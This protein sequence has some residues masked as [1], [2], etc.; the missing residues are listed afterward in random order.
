[1]VCK[2][3][4]IK[5]IKKIGVM[6]SLKLLKDRIVSPFVEIYCLNRW[7]KFSKKRNYLGINK[8]E[9]KIPIIVSMTTFPDRIENVH[10]VIKSLL[11][12][13]F[14]PDKIILWLAEEQ[15]PNKINDLPNNLLKLQQYGL[16]ISWCSDIRSYKK[17]IPTIKNYPNSFIIT[18]DDDIY[19]HPKMIERLFREYKRDPQ[20]I[21]CH[22]VTKFYLE[23][24]EFKAISG[25]YDVYNH[26]SFLNKLTGGSGTLYPPNSLYKDICRQ[27]LF[28]KLAPTNDD[29]WFWVMAILN[30]KRC[31]VVSNSCTA[32][33]YIKGSQDVS[34]SSINDNGE[35]LFWKQFANIMEYYPEAKN[36]LLEEWERERLN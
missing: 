8:S 3:K 30:N 2:M 5:K 1:M 9:R 11:V 13:S 28:M 18:A 27:D 23:N 16:S 31:N 25:G 4:K 33:Y 34:L 19:Y 32:L 29:V 12:Q 21:H 15:F 24:N 20:S 22:R 7:K 14:K 26:P 36:K 17:L 35:K 10:L 6:R